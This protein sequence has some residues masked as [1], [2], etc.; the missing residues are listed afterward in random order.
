VI[1][2][3]A[4]QRSIKN[5]LGAIA[6]SA[7]LL[8]CT[9][10]VEVVVDPEPGINDARSLIEEAVEHNSAGR[11]K[12]ISV[13]KTGGR[14]LKNANADSYELWY[15]VTAQLTQDA[16]WS[17]SAFKRFSSLPAGSPEGQLFH[18][19]KA[20]EQVTIPGTLTFFKSKDGWTIRKD[21]R[22]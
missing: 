3:A 9:Q 20:G 11:L 4:F 13:E 2:R 12:M 16:L 14:R 7:A 21:E 18:A 5:S 8:H 6:I 1:D 15:A 19:A 17:P 22:Y 10:V